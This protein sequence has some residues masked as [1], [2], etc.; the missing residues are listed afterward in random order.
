MRSSSQVRR[1][2]FAAPSR[3][4]LRAEG[5][6]KHPYPPYLRERLE[7][8]VLP[9]FA[10]RVLAFDSTASIA[11]A[12]LMATARAAGAADGYVAATASAANMAVAT[13]D[14]APCQAA[15]VSVIDP[16]A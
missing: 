1:T 2:R 16:W 4:G 12:E 8:R 11:Y 3:C 14:C 7:T 13:R 15:G 10:G 6:P 9:L 5:G